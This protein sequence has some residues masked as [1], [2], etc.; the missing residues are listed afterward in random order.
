VVFAPSHERPDVAL[1]WCPQEG[2]FRALALFGAVEHGAFVEAATFPGRGV[3]AVS[4]RVDG[5]ALVHAVCADRGV[6][7]PRRSATGATGH[8]KLVVEPTG[9]RGWSARRVD[10]GGVHFDP[11]NLRT[12]GA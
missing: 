12:D 10:G 9:R 6:L 8:W 11:I 4:R 1:W 2:F 3:C 5:G 7:R